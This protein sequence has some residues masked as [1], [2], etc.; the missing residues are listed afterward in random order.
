MNSPFKQEL[1]DDRWLSVDLRSPHQILSWAIIGGGL[2]KSQHV[3]WH[4]VGNHDLPLDVDP[5]ELYQNRL[6]EREMPGNVI[7]FLTSARL[8][9]HSIEDSFEDDLWVR[10]LA[11]VGLGNAVRV[12]ERLN[13][14]QHARVGTINLLLQTSAPLTERAMIE[15]MSIIAEARTLAVM[16]S[17]VKTKAGH[18]ATGTGTD[19]IALASPI[20]DQVDL[21]YT[22]KHTK[23][24]LLLGE[25]TR[26]AV[27]LGIEKWKEVQSDKNSSLYQAR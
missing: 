10:C 2:Q 17:R 20:N 27:G 16:D 25:A 24:G 9:N 5:V 21:V 4:R 1:H 3:V 12:G 26:K 22:G 15:A 18:F 13:E 14:K 19:C 6:K 11:T 23:M 8:F 7:G